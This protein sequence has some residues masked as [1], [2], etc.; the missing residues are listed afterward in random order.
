MSDESNNSLRAMPQNADAERAVLS[1]AVQ[2]PGECIVPIADAPGGSDIFYQPSHR[3][4]WKAIHAIHESGRAVDTISLSTE[5]DERGKLESV[6]GPRAVAELL[7]DVP[8]VDLLPDYLKFLEGPYQRRTAIRD[9]SLAVSRLYDIPADSDT[10]SILTEA[11]ATLNGILETGA[12]SDTVRKMNEVMLSAV[13]IL[14]ER[15]N[16]DSPI[17]GIATGFQELDENT[18]GFPRGKPIVI[19]GRP[20]DGK[21]AFGFQIASQ[22][23]TSG[24]PTAV[25][26]VEMFSEELAFRK[27]SADSKIDGLKLSRGDLSKHD[28]SRAIAAAQKSVDLPLWFDDRANMGLP[29]IVATTRKLVR[30][31]GVQCVLVDYLQLIR[32]PDDSR[33]RI[34]AVSKLMA[35]LTAL[36][37]EQNVALIVLAQLNRESTKRK[38]GKPVIADLKDSSSIEQDAFGVLL[39]HHKD[40]NEEEDDGMADTISNVDCIVAKWRGGRTGPVPLHFV[41]PTTTFES[42]AK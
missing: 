22:I 12:S 9:L 3:E 34:D 6:G 40:R 30:E 24:T 5:L 36:A 15:Y 2:W 8:S 14:Q 7:D 23:A 18:N 38:D 16:D 33:N 10:E 27:L 17:P 25:F 11:N 20:G 35:G 29:H 4:I 39:L 1:C 31:H 42:I 32:E 19:G 26:S 41:K 13:E 28:F 37:K 21:T